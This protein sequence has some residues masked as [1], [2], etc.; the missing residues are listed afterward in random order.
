MRI[1]V[2]IPAGGA[3]RRMGGVFKPLLELDGVPLLQR[4]LRPFVERTD[5][6]WIV[7]ALPTDLI[8]EPPA[9]LLEDARVGVVAG[10]AER[11]DSVRG[12]LAAVPHEAEVVLVHDAARPLVSADIIARCIAAA[13]DGRS[14]IAAVPVVDTLKEV[15]EGGR[16]MS[17][18]DR[19]RMWAA[20]TPQAFPAG[21]LRAAHARAEAEGVST[22]DDAALVARYGGTVVV[23]E[24]S[25]DN[26]KITTPADLAVA[27]ALLGVP[28]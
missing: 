9:W 13:R 23:V 5:V 4:S 16:I 14:A 3:G 27:E 18:P 20:Q 6:E 12:A 26:L 2:V 15:D 22:T 1:A 7:V 8:A 17:T 24:G 19:R 11:S 28:R 10:G 21:V 25:A